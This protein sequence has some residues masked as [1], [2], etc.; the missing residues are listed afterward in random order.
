M[1]EDVLEKNGDDN[2]FCAIIVS[3][4]VMLRRIAGKKKI[5]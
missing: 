4:M 5:R 2:P 3:D 1:D